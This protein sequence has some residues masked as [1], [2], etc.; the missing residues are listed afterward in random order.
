MYSLHTGEEVDYATP[1]AEV[2]TLLVTVITMRAQAIMHG[3]GDRYRHVFGARGGTAGGYD[4]TDG[5]SARWVRRRQVEAGSLLGRLLRIPSC[6]ALRFCGRRCEMML[7]IRQA[8]S[9]AA[10]FIREGLSG[11]ILYRV[12]SKEEKVPMKSRPRNLRCRQMLFPA[13]R[14]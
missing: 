1:P 6:W 9:A 3:R 7:G 10:A 2:P 14:K 5:G 12:I 4:R 11:T 8:V 13:L